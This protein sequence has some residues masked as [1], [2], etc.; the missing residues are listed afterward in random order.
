M[1]GR[2]V[3]RAIR[4]GL[5]KR[6]PRVRKYEHWAVEFENGEK[7]EPDLIVFATGFNYLKEDLKQ[8]VDFDPDGRPIVKNCESTRV[9]GMFLLG[10]RFGRTFASPY[11]RG[12]ARDAEFVAKRIA[13]DK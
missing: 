7:I 10:Y 1:T 8:V 12:I 9:P 11:L 6:V 2:A 3:V 5:I 4:K 13:R